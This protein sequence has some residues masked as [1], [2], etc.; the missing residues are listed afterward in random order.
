[1]F[2]LLFYLSL[3]KESKKLVK[4]G[5]AKIVKCQVCGKWGLDNGWVCTNCGWIQDYGL[6]SRDDDL[7]LYNNMSIAEYE[8]YYSENKNEI[9]KI[10]AKR[11]YDLWREWRS[12][13]KS[14]Q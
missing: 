5:Y 12:I 8:R 4:N 2:K 1:M 3:S 10:R 6:K 9:R 11:R 13:K 7:S 14:L